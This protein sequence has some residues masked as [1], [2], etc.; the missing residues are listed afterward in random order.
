MPDNLSPEQEDPEQRI[1][2]L[3]RG[4]ADIDHRA[5]QYP[6]AQQYPQPPQYPQAPQYQQGAQYPPVPGYGV[7]PA[8]STPAWPAQ[9]VPW[10]APGARAFGR[11]R[12]GL[13]W[14]GI[15][16]F[17]FPLLIAV[18]FIVPWKD[19]GVFAGLFGPTKVPQGGSL[20]VNESNKTKTIECNDGKL[21]LNGRNLEVTVTGHCAHLFVNGWGHRVTVDSADGI[22]VNGGDTVV[23][24][25]SGEPTIDKNGK[26]TVEQG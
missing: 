1:R 13:P 20:M 10:G 8:A 5:P 21:T 19:F 23:V 22:Q 4:L 3:E 6:E 16:G 15:L 14:I 7:N 17:A 26:V 9:P 24:Y 12:G 11:R 2:E 25:H 18:V